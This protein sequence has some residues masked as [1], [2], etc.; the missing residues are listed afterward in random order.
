MMS[1]ARCTQR[2]TR[3]SRSIGFVRSSFVNKIIGFDT[4]VAFVLVKRFIRYG[5]ARIDAV[6]IRR[7]ERVRAEFVDVFSVD[8]KN[9]KQ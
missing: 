7:T 1:A 5:H 2:S 3:T 8:E 6:I 4:S 9:R